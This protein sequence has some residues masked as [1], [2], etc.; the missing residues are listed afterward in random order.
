M[1]N[2]DL[3]VYVIR[4]YVSIFMEG[5]FKVIQTHFTRWVLD[6][7]DLEGDY[8]KRRVAMVGME[9]PYK[10]YPLKKQISTLAQLVHTNPKLVIDREG[11][12]HK[13]VKTKMYKIQVKPVVSVHKSVK[14]TWICY[15][16]GY[17]TPIVVTKPPKYISIIDMMGSP[18]LFDT[19]EGLPESPRLR[20]KL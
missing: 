7:P 10:L 16:Q 3:P 4:A 6:C 14:G 15:I 9:L 13:W 17:H 8:F 12:M 18:I 11:K 20:V 2:F 5:N 1:L 19:H